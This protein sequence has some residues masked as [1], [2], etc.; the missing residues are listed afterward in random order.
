M[1]DDT[2]INKGGKLILGYSFDKDSK[3]IYN[4]QIKG[5]ILEIIETEELYYSYYK[6]TILPRIKFNLIINKKKIYRLY[7][8]L[9][10]L[11]P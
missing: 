6:I 2:K 4:E 1:N 9:R 5:Y 10:I 8:E 7:K 3:C 11:K